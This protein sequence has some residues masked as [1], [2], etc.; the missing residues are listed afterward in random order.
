MYLPGF[1]HRLF[2]SPAARAAGKV[3]GRVKHLDGVGDKTS[4]LDS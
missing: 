4:G 3:A 2:G 1:T